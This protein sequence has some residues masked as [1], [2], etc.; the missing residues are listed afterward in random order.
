MS[1]EANKKKVSKSG[2]LKKETLE[3]WDE[4]RRATLRFFGAGGQERSSGIRNLCPLG[5]EQPL[6]VAFSPSPS[7]SSMVGLVALGMQWNPFA[8]SL[9]F[10]DRM[11][12]SLYWVLLVFL[13]L[14]AIAEIV[15]LELWC[16]EWG[17][18]TIETLGIDPF[19]SLAA[20]HAEFSKIS[21]T[22]TEISIK[23]DSPGFGSLNIKVSSRFG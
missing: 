6:L 21:R 15:G 17:N 14:G 16:C 3:I 2:G 19:V 22:P 10:F 23:T 4:Q 1:L 11:A 18:A 9:A 20:N 7:S 5:V 12:R 13:P 8:D